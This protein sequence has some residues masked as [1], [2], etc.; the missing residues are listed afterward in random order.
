[1]YTVDC[2]VV[3]KEMNKVMRNS[4]SMSQVSAAWSTYMAYLKD[5]LENYAKW[6][7]TVAWR[8]VPCDAAQALREGV[9]GVFEQFQSTSS[10]K[11]VAFNWD[12]TLLKVTGGGY[13]IIE[14]SAFPNEAEILME[15]S[16]AF[17]VTDVEVEN[18]KNVITMTTD[19]EDSH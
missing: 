19:P 9:T 2:P 17:F 7:D 3:Y 4:K 15:A 16:R 6:T 14:Y 12:C 10:N 13:V 8:G 1:M 11:Q 5:G 18:G